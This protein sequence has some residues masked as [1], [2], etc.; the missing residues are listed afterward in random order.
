MNSNK[1]T[2]WVEKYRPDTLDGYIGNDVIVGKMKTYIE[3]G[4][5]PHLLFYGRAGTGKTTLA[6]I[7]INNIDCDHIYINAS[8]ENNVETIRT[9]VKGFVSTMSLKPLK[10][11]VLDEA[12]YISPSGQAALR[13][14]MEV[15]SD[16]ARFILTCNFPERIIDPLISRTQS[17]DLTPPSHKETAVH[18]VNVLTEEGVEYELGDIK[19]LVVSYHPDIRKIINTAQLFS[20]SGKLALDL[21]QLIGSDVKLN[22]LSTLVGNGSMQNKFKDIREDIYK[23]GIRDFSEF[24]GFFYGN[25]DTFKEKAQ[26]SIILELAD[27][28]A[29]DSYVA[30]KEINFAALIYK[31]LEHIHS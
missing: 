22:L 7:I 27:A 6:K 3:G 18:L 16:V 5:I 8:D 21:D 19:T 17:F 11:V 23:A 10:I 9:R 26:A 20:K 1:N 12:D 24:Y 13:S 30:D 14:L 28:Q 25:L 4:D 31:M 2:L 29:R 15:F